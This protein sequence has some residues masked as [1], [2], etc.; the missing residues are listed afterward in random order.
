MA[1]GVLRWTHE[2]GE[3]SSLGLEHDIA[4]AF[5]RAKAENWA[6]D[7]ESRRDLR[8]LLVAVLMAAAWLGPTKP[9][10]MVPQPPSPE[11]TDIILRPAQREDDKD[12][13]DA[14]TKGLTAFVLRN[15]PAPPELVGNTIITTRAGEEGLVTN[16][17]NTSAFGAWGAAA[18]VGVAGVVGAVLYGWLSQK[19][20]I[21]YVGL[22]ADTK[23]KQT[24]AELA[25]AA[26][27]I[28]RHKARE[29]REGRSLPY[30]QEE[31]RFL[32]TLNA[33]IETLTHWKAPPP[34]TL[35]NVTE[36]SKGIGNAI[37]NAGIGAGVALPLA[38]VAAAFLLLK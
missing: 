2:S 5:A 36:V 37:D 21:A 16:A 33:S 34:K 30:D 14:L 23:A 1:A 29:E 38:A 6:T 22:E 8:A 17:L 11:Y 26:E 32:D 7:D 24:A 35:P 4:R 18:V 20:E 19:N 25:T 27:V 13:Q 28:E 15:R 31:L 3:T 10:R 9:R 12:W